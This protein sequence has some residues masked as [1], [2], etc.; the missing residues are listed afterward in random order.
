MHQA[1]DIKRH[2][3]HRTSILREFIGGRRNVSRDGFN[4]Y[5]DATLITCRSLWALIGV[6]TFSHNETDL[7]TPSGTKLCFDGF[8]RIRKNI[9][10]SVVITPFTAETQLN[11]LPEKQQII[12]VLAA[13]NKCV[14]HFDNLLDHGV[15]EED[16]EA[17]AKRLLDE[18]SARIQIPA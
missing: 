11:A 8:K 17:V 14:A 15:R 10:P 12:Q 1:N 13:A 2:L 6:E 3:E 5:M 18:I 9:E 4:C 7:K 16:L